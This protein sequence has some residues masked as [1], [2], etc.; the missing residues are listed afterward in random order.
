MWHEFDT[1]VILVA[2]PKN[3]TPK[4]VFIVKHGRKFTLDFL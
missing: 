1:H 2:L 3:T 4:E